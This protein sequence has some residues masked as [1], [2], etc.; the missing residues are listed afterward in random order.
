MLILSSTSRA[1]CTC[2]VPS[3]QIHSYINKK[4]FRR[5]G[6][7]IWA[8]GFYICSQG[9]HLEHLKTNHHIVHTVQPETRRYLSGLTKNMPC[10]ERDYISCFIYIGLFLTST[11]YRKPETPRQK[12]RSEKRK[13]QDTFSWNSSPRS[14]LILPS[15]FIWAEKN[16]GQGKRRQLHN[17]R[18]HHGAHTQH[19]NVSVL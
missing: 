9:C 12:E 16:R 5:S 17:Y 18:P 13:Q 6:T 14:R 19:N 11:L 7:Q 2:A 1:V 15:N 10:C 4:G 8:C 3:R